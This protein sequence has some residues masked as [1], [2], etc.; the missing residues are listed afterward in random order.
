MSSAS[1]RHSRWTDVRPLDR[2]PSLKIKL[3]ALVVFSVTAAALVTWLGLQFRLGPT[4]TFPVAMAIA[5]TL[6]YLLAHGMTSPLRQMRD[7]VQAMAAGDYSRPVVATS[8]DEVGQLAKAFN[9]MASELQAEDQARRD[10]V[11]NVAHEIRT[12]I[13]ALQAQLENLVDGV[14]EPT[15]AVL[16]SSLRQTERLTRL[17]TYLLD[18]S[19]IDAGTAPLRIEPIELAQFLNECTNSTFVAASQAAVTVNTTVSPRDMVLHADPDRLEQ[20]L[21]NLVDN[22]IRHSPAGGTVTVAASGN[23]SFV[24][25]DVI[26]QGPGIPRAERERVFSRFVSGHASVH[27]GQIPAVGTS[28]RAGDS[29]RPRPTG[30]TGIG[31]SIVRWAVELHGGRVGV[32]DSPTGLIMRVTLPRRPSP[33]RQSQS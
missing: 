9:A 16:A 28:E 18:L 6:T 7:S 33:Q 4:R 24:F 12:P 17:V 26:D 31:L 11:A 14:S 1:P 13:A 25:I 19:R 10:L 32:V 30:G 29:P 2:I 5:L 15:P 27:T 23:S 21:I 8:R 3:G 22:A 20:V